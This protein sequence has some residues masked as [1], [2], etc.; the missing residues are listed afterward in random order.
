MEC[1]VAAAIL[2]IG[3]VGVASMFTYASVSDRKATYMAQAREIADRALE[4]LRT[5]GYSRFTQATGTATIATPELPRSSGVMAWQPY[6]AASPEAGLKLVAVN[7][8]WDWPKPTAGT[9][10]V[11]TL[12]SQQGGL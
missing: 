6:P 8:T 2:A 3:V 4:D 7:I 9:Y 10:R 12:V 11:V 1:L 5:S